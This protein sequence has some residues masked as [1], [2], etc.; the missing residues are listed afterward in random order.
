MTKIVELREK[1]GKIITDARAMLEAADNDKRKLTPEESAKWDAMFA[2]ADAIK[3]DVD[4][5]E[6]LEAQEHELAR[7]NRDQRPTAAYAETEVAENREVVNRE[8]VNRE[9]VSN[10]IRAWALNGTDECRSDDRKAA[11]TLGIDTSRKELTFRFNRRAPK[12][13]RKFSQSI[14]ER[15]QGVASGAAGLFTVADE[16]MSGIEISLLAFGGMRE[17]ATVIRTD[18][19]A[20]MPVPTVNDTGQ[21]GVILAE[22]TAVA[23]QDVTFAQIVLQA[24]KYS[25]KQVLVSVEL[26]QDSAVDIPALLGR[27]L[28]ERIARILNTHFTTGTGTGQPNGIVTASSAGVTGG[29]GVVGV[30]TADNLIDLLHSLDPAYRGPNTAWMMRDSSVATLHKLKE[31]TNQYIWQP[32]LQAGQPDLLLG[33]PLIVNQDIAAT[34]LSAKSVIFGDISKYWIRDTLP[35][36]LLR[37]DERYADLHQVGFLAFGRFDGDLIDSGTDPVKHF[38]GNAA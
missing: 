10:A 24:Y 19:G 26:L 28:G 18:T 7:T 11:Q 23:N 20:D 9:M 32:G 35:F 5:R 12:N 17:M 3:K 22:N 30:F 14:E 21:V 36:S 38:I 34:A 4:Q 25:S 29:A 37:L 31:T 8:M 15:A 27:L 1:R 33:F 6:Q 16:V 13:L 2:D